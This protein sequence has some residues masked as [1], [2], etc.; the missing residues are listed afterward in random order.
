MK[1]LKNQPK[2]TENK[3]VFEVGFCWNNTLL[4]AIA[5]RESSV[6]DPPVSKIKLCSWA[7]CSGVLLKNVAQLFRY[8]SKFRV[9]TKKFF[10]NL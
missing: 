7:N 5:S 4:L 10:I 3:E 8:V 2:L 9:F 6:R 1:I